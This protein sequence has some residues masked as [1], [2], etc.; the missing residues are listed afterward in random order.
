M[1]HW[2]QGPCKITCCDSVAELRTR[3]ITLDRDTRLVPKAIVHVQA[4]DKLNHSVPFGVKSFDVH[5]T[6]RIV[7][8]LM[9]QV[10]IDRSSAQA[11][12]YIRS[13]LHFASSVYRLSS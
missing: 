5:F 3:R 10:S 8:Y 13:F 6:L 2:N 9:Y 12:P 7:P 1:L 4:A 11:A